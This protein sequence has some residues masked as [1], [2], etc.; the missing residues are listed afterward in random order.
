MS[1]I[2]AIYCDDVRQELGGKLS[3]MGVYR[4]TIG[5]VGPSLMMQKFVAVALFDL[6]LPLSGAALEISFKDRDSLLMPPMVVQPEANGAPDGMPQMRHLPVA[7]PIEMMGFE[8]KAGMVLHISV[9]YGEVEVDSPSLLAFS[10][11]SVVT[12][13]TTQ[14]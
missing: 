10:A 2:T 1:P 13:G 11:P 9:K 12:T 3:Y 6:P 5:F 7:V 4:D 14:N 8:L